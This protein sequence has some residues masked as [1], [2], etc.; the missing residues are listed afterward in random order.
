MI[1]AKNMILIGST[2]K[3]SGKT[4]LAAEFVRRWRDRVPVVALKA[5]TVSRDGGGCPYGR[6]G[7]GVCS[8][9]EADYLLTREEERDGPKDTS[10]L[11]AAGAH[12]VFWLRS[13]REALSEAYGRFREEALKGALVICESNSLREYVEPG[14]FIMMQN[15][16]GPGKPS[17][18]RVR[19]MADLTAANRF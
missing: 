4:A 19:E 8:S 1:S 16:A 2:G 17:S 7:C 3:N 14:C 13:T 12:Q 18:Q 6:H 5:T 11:L 9:M 15:A 10:R